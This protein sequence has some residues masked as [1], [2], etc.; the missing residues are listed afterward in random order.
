MHILVWFFSN[1][2]MTKSQ[3]VLAGWLVPVVIVMFNM[4]F[5]YQQYGGS[6]H[7]WLQ[8]DTNLIYGQFVPIALMTIVSLAVIEA[9]GD[10]SDYEKLDKVDKEQRKTAK[11]MQ[12]TLILILPMVIFS[13]IQWS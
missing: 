6:Y 1:G 4:C 2:L 11:I 3:N 10:A 8:M 13:L 9:A 5:E 12:R 7:C